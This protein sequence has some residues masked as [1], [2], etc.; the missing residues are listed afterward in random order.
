MCV[1]S[2]SNISPSSD[3]EPEK[4]E[5]NGGTDTSIDSVLRTNVIPSKRFQLLL[6]SKWDSVFLLLSVQNLQWGIK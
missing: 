4:I 1:D 2:E 3:Y 5:F 6:V